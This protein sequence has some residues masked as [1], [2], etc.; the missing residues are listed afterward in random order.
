MI[1]NCEHVCQQFPFSPTDSCGLKRMRKT[2]F[3]RLNTIRHFAV[4]LGILSLISGC[5]DEPSAQV[6]A[7]ANHASNETAANV[8]ISKPESSEEKPATP[9]TEEIFELKPLTLSNLSG[10]S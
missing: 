10:N 5:A 3:S 2:A 9:V 1:W 4:G 7:P 8:E 6:P